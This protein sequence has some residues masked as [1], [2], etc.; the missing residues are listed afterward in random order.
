MEN[1]YQSKAVVTT[2]KAT[3]K[4]TLKIKDNFFSVEY[5]EERTIP[6]VEGI[7]I[8]KE[9]KILF[10][11]VNATVDDQASEIRNTFK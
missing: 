6:D 2:I 4:V 5:T 11:D 9:R 7:D 1:E 8:D 10:D 3:S